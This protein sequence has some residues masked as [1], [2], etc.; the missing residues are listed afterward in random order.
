M[1]VAERG[2]EWRLFMEYTL[3][4]SVAVG[5]QDNYFIWK[6]LIP[7]LWWSR[8]LKSGCIRVDTGSTL[9]ISW[10][11]SFAMK[12]WKVQEE[13]VYLD[14]YKLLQMVK[15]SE[16]WFKHTHFI[17]QRRSQVLCLSSDG[18]CIQ[19]VGAVT[20][21]T[22]PAQPFP[23][24]LCFQLPFLSKVDLVLNSTA[25]HTGEVPYPSAQLVVGGSESYG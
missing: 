22:K 14:P 16:M 6:G 3:K 18:C 19:V 9:A 7:L 5:K 13:K 8:P 2:H 11:F 23:A 24:Y 21:P 17:S 20:S 25:S 10:L 12:I 15:W 1:A 4:E